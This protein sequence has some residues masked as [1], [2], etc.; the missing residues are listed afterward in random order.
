MLIVTMPVFRSHWMNNAM[1]LILVTS[2]SYSI[3][4][5]KFVAF[6]IFL[7]NTGQ[8]PSPRKCVIWLGTVWETTQHYLLKFNFNLEQLLTSQLQRY[9]LFQWILLDLCSRILFPSKTMT[10]TT[11]NCLKCFYSK[12]KNDNRSSQCD[13][14]NK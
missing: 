6:G 5:H 10:A 12:K 11:K 2:D 13:L 8:T 3:N 4:G 9:V 1:E 14:K 7:F